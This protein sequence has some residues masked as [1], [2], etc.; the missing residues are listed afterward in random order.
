MIIVSSC[1]GSITVSIQ[2]FF[3]FDYLLL[4]GLGSVLFGPERRRQVCM[5]QQVFR[6]R[7]FNGAFAKLLVNNLGF[8]MQ[9]AGTGH[10]RHLDAF[11]LFDFANVALYLR[12]ILSKLRFSDE[13]DND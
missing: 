11:V 1:G 8:C 6:R 2:I 10:C 7:E 3:L 5:S 9:S 4:A 13:R 12:M